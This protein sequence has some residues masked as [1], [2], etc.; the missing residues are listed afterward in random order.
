MNK[1]IHISVLAIFIAATLVG[2][3]VSTGDATAYAT[4][5]DSSFQGIDQGQ[6]NSPGA[7]CV[8]GGSDD[9]P[10][11]QDKADKKQDKADKKQDKAD[12]KREHFDGVFAS[13]NNVGLDLQTNDGKL[14]LGQR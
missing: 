5:S 11:G 1:K 9:K 3:V 8:V 12:K 4:L 7:Q 6:S 13:C 14:A 2:S 10:N